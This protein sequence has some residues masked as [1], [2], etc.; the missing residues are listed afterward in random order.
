MLEFQEDFFQQEIRN[1]FYL[2]VTMKTVWAAEL[3]LLQKVAEVCDKYGL[4]WYAAYGTLLGAI[5]HEGFVPWDDDMDIWMKRA[6]YNKL[7]EVLQQELPKGYVVHSALSERGNDQFHTCV[8]NGTGINVSKE[9]LEQFHGCPFTVGLDIFPLDYL[10]REESKRKLQE[11]L[12]LLAASAAQIARGLDRGEF[13]AAEGEDA[14]VARARKADVINRMKE[15]IACLKENCGFDINEQLLKEERWY[16]LSSEMWKWANQV[17]MMYD[18]QESDHLV[19]YL[20][21]YKWKHKKY[22]KEWFEDIYSATFENVMLPIPC[23]YEKVLKIIYGNY[24]AC[25]RKTGMHEYPYYA[26]QLREV[27]K[28]LKQRTDL[29]NGKAGVEETELPQDVMDIPG[30]WQKCM[31]NSNGEHKKVILYANDVW[32]YAFYGEEGLTRIEKV[33]NYFFEHRDILTLWWRP[34]PIMKHVLEQVGLEL[35]EHYQKLLDDYKSA[36]FGIC[37]ESDAVERA[38]KYCDA[39]YG[40][41]NAIIQPF[42]NEGKSI[43]IS[44]LYGEE[45]AYHINCNR[46]VENNL[47]FSTSDAVEVGEKIYFSNYNYNALI[48]LDKHTLKPSQ[49]VC[50]SGLNYKEKQIHGQILKMESR[51]IFVPRGNYPLHMY[52][53]QSGKQ[54]VLHIPTGVKAALNRPWY[55]HLCAGK[56]YLF[57]C[58]GNMGLW[59]VCDKAA[60][61]ENWW[62]IECTDKYFIHGQVSAEKVYSLEI[63]TNR[64][65]VTNLI[66]HEI[67]SFE[68]PDEQIYRLFY[69]GTDYWYITRNRFDVVRWNTAVGLVKRYEFQAWDLCHHTGLPY[70]GLGV[71]TQNIYLVS[72]D[73]TGLYKI[74]KEIGNRELLVNLSDT[75]ALPLG[76]EPFFRAYKDNLYIFF[77]SAS[78]VVQIDQDSSAVSCYTDCKESE[79]ICKPYEDKM[80]LEI[81][82]LLYEESDW[83]MEKY[84]QAVA[85]LKE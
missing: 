36:G 12:F 10:P 41:M 5:R 52:D 82:T 17:A 28:L 81:G 80:L 74:N 84:L 24:H 2:D 57:P 34:Q 1:G 73:S 44:D 75:F 77:D 66:T 65:Y 35:A 27:R 70:Y 22:P 8:N 25:V 7:M 26:R 53:L 50:F 79:M 72:G 18:E 6:D 59:S 45:D 39:Y 69:D 83:T 21:Y 64:M 3:E 46:Y 63:Y 23:G 19:M 71:D 43:M 37:D 11:N 31:H 38:V 58:Y 16:E 62:N 48:E 67:E 51:L 9:W 4:A 56:I 29:I 49:M 47:I 76:A 85:E 14:S 61:K 40:D 32:I 33:L 15:E 55:A 42:Q 20:D 60:N 68:L 30:E 78:G 54:E 13:A